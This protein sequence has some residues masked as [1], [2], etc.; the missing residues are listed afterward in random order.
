M[1]VYNTMPYYDFV[2][3]YNKY[4]VFTIDSECIIYYINQ[5]HL[6]QLCFQV[7]YSLWK[8]TV[9]LA[10]VVSA[11]ASVTIVLDALYD[12]IYLDKFMCKCVNGS[13]LGYA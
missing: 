9:S 7:E 12:Y 1:V 3:N 13:I 2:A 8:Q 11:D 5:P 6:V 10:L 4:R